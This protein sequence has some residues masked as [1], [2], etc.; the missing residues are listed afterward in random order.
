MGSRL[1]VAHR[2]ISAPRARASDGDEP[3][4]TSSPGGRFT[5][6]LTQGQSGTPGTLGRRPA[7]VRRRP[8]AAL[9]AMLTNAW[10]SLS[11]GPP[12]QRAP[13]TRR[14]AW[15][16]AEAASGAAARS[17][18]SEAAADVGL[19]GERT[20]E[21]MLATS[22]AV[23][24]AVQHGKPWPNE[25]ILLSTEPCP[26]GVRVEVTDCGTFD[27]Q[28]EPAALDDTTGRGIQIIAAIVDRLEVQNGNGRTRV[29]FEKHTAA[30]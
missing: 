22:E 9:A 3:P 6:G 26:Q 27:S 30:A 1:V 25:C 21:L 2:I 8:T 5:Q 24:N 7:A 17:I 20:W 14:E 23:A 11:G 28:L 15:L 19:D 13:D 16:P 10:E 18:V 12:T 29:R 4:T